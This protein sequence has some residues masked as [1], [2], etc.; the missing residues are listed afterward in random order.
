MKQMNA[1]TYLLITLACAA[2]AVLQPV[3]AESLD[4]GSMVAI[5]NQVLTSLAVDDTSVAPAQ[6]E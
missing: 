1:P 5:T 4:A 6:A 3:E 2:L